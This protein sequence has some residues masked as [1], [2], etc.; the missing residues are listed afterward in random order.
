MKQQSE[1]WLEFQKG[2]QL[3]GST[4]YSALG[5]R[6]LKDQKL[7]YRKYVNKEDIVQITTPAMQDRTDHEVR[8]TV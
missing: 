4:I 7:Q 8:T 1:L 6:T 3:T 5:L 2:S